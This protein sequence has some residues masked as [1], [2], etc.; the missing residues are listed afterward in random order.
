MAQ[1]AAIRRN[2]RLQDAINVRTA[3]R[4]YGVVSPDR[5]EEM[6]AGGN[7]T[8]NQPQPSNDVSLVLLAIMGVLLI[9]AVA[10]GVWAWSQRQPVSTP[11]VSVAP[12]TPLAPVPT[13]EYLRIR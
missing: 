7:I 13:R 9:L 10:F 3:A 11:S 2:E 8:V 1:L 12:V 6:L 4:I 5:D